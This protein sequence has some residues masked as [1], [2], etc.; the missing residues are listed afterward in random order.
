[1]S[2]LNVLGEG[3]VIVVRPREVPSGSRRLART[4]AALS[5]SPEYAR[6][7][8]DPRLASAR[9]SRRAPRPSGGRRYF[10]DAP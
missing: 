10:A 2:E 5:E 1:D 8:V 9:T 4:L 6:Y 7:E 3:I